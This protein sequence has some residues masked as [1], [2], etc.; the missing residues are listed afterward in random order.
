MSWLY[1]YLISTV[2]CCE[3]TLLS[4]S[5]HIVVVVYDCEKFIPENVHSSYQYTQAPP[6]YT[7]TT[8]LLLKSG[9]YVLLHIIGFSFFWLCICKW[10]CDL[11]IVVPLCFYPKFFK[12]AIIVEEHGKKNKQTKQE[13]TRS[14]WNGTIF[15]NA[16]SSQFEVPAFIYVN[17]MRNM[18]GRV[19]TRFAKKIN[20][21]KSKAST[22]ITDIQFKLLM[23]HPINGYFN[24]IQS[25]PFS[26]ETPE[27]FLFWV[28]SNKRFY[29]HDEK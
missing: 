13:H 1:C 22:T 5:V 7:T 10:L 21:F 14:F 11:Y 18:Y 28:V 6:P 2:S 19:R 3:N 16:K 27:R 15:L 25:F 26:V 23:N 12:L 24:V 20:K 4:I 29:Q 8:Y 9:K 17:F